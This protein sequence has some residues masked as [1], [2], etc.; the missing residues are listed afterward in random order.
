M[1]KKNSPLNTS[2][3]VNSDNDVNIDNIR[4]RIRRLRIQEGILLQ[5]LQKPNKHA[6]E[7][8]KSSATELNTSE[9]KHLV[10]KVKDSYINLK[11]L[12]DEVKT[13]TQSQELLA[14][15]G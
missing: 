6:S 2:K 10:V 5:S 8:K 15:L 7:D 12:F 13:T 11:N 3:L 14:D 4:S 1:N 9:H